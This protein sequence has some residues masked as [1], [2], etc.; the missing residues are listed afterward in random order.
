[1]YFVMI[2]EKK[3]EQLR[4]ITSPIQKEKIKIVVLSI[5]NVLGMKNLDSFLIYG[6]GDGTWQDEGVCVFEGR[7]MP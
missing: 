3:D 1:M 4:C 2:E 6:R 5:L 7:L